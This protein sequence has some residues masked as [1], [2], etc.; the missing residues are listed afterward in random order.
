MIKIER[1]ES[2]V[3]P[4]FMRNNTRQPLALFQML[5]QEEFDTIELADG[6]VTYSVNESVLLT[7]EPTST[8]STSTKP[9]E[10]KPVVVP[11]T[12]KIVQPKKTTK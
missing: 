5:S 1:I 4:T 12:P 9:T 10:V 2:S 11:A 3:R 8:K 7:L 6:R